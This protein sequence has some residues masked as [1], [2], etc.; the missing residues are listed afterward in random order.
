LAVNVTGGKL[1]LSAVNTYT[2]TTTLT[3]S[4]LLV[5]GSISSPVNVLNAGILGG[6][7]TINGALTNQSGGILFPGAGTNLAGAVLIESSGTSRVDLA[8]GS[9]SKFRVKTGNISDQLN[10]SGITYG[11]TITVVT[12]VGDAPLV[13]GDKFTLFY[14]GLGAYYGSFTSSNLPPLASGLGWSNSFAVDGSIEVVSNAFVT[15]TPIAGVTNLTTTVG[16]A[17]LSVTFSNY[18]TGATGYY[19]TFG[20]GGTLATNNLVNISYTYSTPGTYTNILSAI[21]SGVT[22]NATNVNAIVVYSPAVA[23]FGGTPTNGFGPLQ[24]VFTNSS[25]GTIT[26]WVWNFGV[27]SSVTNSSGVNVTNTYAVG[28]YTVALTVSGPGGT[29]TSTQTSYITVKP[30]AVL[31]KPM[32]QS[33]NFIFSGTN[34]PAGVQYSILSS[35]NVATALASWTPLVTNTF[36]ND[37]TY[38]FTYASP[39]NKARFF[40]LKSPP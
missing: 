11:G 28:Q 19:W 34:G 33:G 37:G 1:T 6:S 29:N 23:G 18:S 3:N 36:N 25:T 40:R 15:P 32:I 21:N 27:G 13:Y 12:N 20:D 4:T 8:S 38:S 24:V 10:C 2:G 39:T 16:V 17:P 35:T 31:G 9:T 14:S 7:G 26:N 30:Q 5:N 22:N